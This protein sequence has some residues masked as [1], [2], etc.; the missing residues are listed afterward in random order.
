MVAAAAVV[1][2]VLL[3]AQEEAIGGNGLQARNG[4]VTTKEIRETLEETLFELVP[5]E[6]EAELV[7]TAGVT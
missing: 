2:Q 4:V 5:E 3:E 1:V 6:G 7:V